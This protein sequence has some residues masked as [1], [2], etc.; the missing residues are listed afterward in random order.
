MRS[1]PQRRKTKSE[2]NLNPPSVSVSVSV[3]CSCAFTMIPSA[4]PSP[5]HST[6]FV[7]KVLVVVM[8]VCFCVVAV[9]AAV[10]FFCWIFNC[11][12][13]KPRVVPELQM[14]P[15]VHDN[16][17]YT[18]WWFHSYPLCRQP[19]CCPSRGP[20]FNLCSII[21]SWSCLSSFRF[22]VREFCLYIMICRID[23]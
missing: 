23:S 1:K 19:I 16:W 4:I 12:P 20:R 14:L 8:L 6:P 2:R 3:S 21:H 22:S 11:Y 5:S 13:K 10:V 18:S 15:N 7:I 17:Q 9:V